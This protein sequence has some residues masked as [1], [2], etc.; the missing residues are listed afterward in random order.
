MHLLR[1]IRHKIKGPYWSL[2]RRLNPKAYLRHEI[3]CDPECHDW[4]SREDLL[5]IETTE[6]TRRAERI[7]ISVADIPLPEKAESHWKTAYDGT[8]YLPYDSLRKLK[9]AVEDAEY[10]RDRRKR[11]GREMWVKY[12]TA[13]A[14]ALAALAS[15]ANLY[16]TSRKR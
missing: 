9:R 2:V 4:G 5:S 15:L 16:F 8:G 10:Q 7:H 11:E 12:F 13:G 3:A 14:A 6:W 1:R